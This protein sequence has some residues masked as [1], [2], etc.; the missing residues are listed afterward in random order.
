M[1]NFDENKFSTVP[2]WKLWKT[3]GK[4]GENPKWP[5][6]FKGR[7]REVFHNFHRFV[8]ENFLFGFSYFLHFAY[9]TKKER[10]KIRSE[11][12]KTRIPMAATVFAADLGKREEKEQKR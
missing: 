5:H 2:L 9:L 10:K 4:I 7:D 6:P 12:E 8:V 1:M 3:P 11:M